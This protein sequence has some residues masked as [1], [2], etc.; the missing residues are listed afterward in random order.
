MTFCRHFLGVFALLVLPLQAQAASLTERLQEAESLY[1]NGEFLQAASLYQSL[2]EE[3]DLQTGPLL[4]NLANSFAKAG[5]RGHAIAAYLKARRFL[6]RSADIDFNLRYLMQKNRDTVGN[7]PEELP[8]VKG[9]PPVVALA[10]RELLYASGILIFVGGAL[11]GFAWYG[12]RRRLQLLACL[13]LLFPGL[14]GFTVIMQRDA[15][16]INWAAVASEE[17]SI[18]SSPGS[19]SGVV[20]FKLHEGTPVRFVKQ[21]ESRILIELSDQKRGWIEASQLALF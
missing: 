21:E 17:V 9:I 4:F 13:L 20:L 15:L 19:E 8:L 3:Q 11:F 10:P 7:S 14:L 16:W 2:M 6:P 5:E 1:H 12:R 18:Y